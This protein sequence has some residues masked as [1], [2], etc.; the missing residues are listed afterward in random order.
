M[1]KKQIHLLDLKTLHTFQCT[2]V[3]GI[4]ALK[5]QKAVFP[6]FVSEIPIFKSI[7][8]SGFKDHYLILAPN[9]TMEFYQNPDIFNQKTATSTQQ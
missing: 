4:S 9:Q 8:Y 2:G 6:V 7:K 3:S 1:E 5:S